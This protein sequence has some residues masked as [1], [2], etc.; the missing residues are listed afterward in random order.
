MRPGRNP[1]RLKSALSW[2][3]EFFSPFQSETELLQRGKPAV[4]PRRLVQKN[5][6]IF[7]M[8]LNFTENNKFTSSE[9]ELSEKLPSTRRAIGE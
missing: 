3:N 8:N 1:Q 9:V 4:E 7:K 2:N 6:N 5:V